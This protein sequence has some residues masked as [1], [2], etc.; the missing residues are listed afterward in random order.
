[1][2]YKILRQL[3]LSRFYRTGAQEASYWEVISQLRNF[4]K[5]SPDFASQKFDNFCFRSRFRHYLIGT[6]LRKTHSDRQFWSSTLMANFRS[7]C[8]RLSLN[9]VPNSKTAKLATEC[10]CFTTV[11]RWWLLQFNLRSQLHWVGWTVITMPDDH[12]QMVKRLLHNSRACSRNFKLEIQFHNKI[13]DENSFAEVPS[14]YY[15]R[16]GL[17]SSKS[18]ILTQNIEFLFKI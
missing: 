6:I 3:R 15:L 4:L 1:M 16:T 13:F 17:S 8:G 11:R 9:L 7:Q 5:C 18:E 2:I 14:R 10:D 12:K